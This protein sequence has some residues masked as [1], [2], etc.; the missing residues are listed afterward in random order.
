MTDI[1]R[2]LNKRQDI[3][4]ALLQKRG[5]LGVVEI[6]AEIGQK[7]GETAK[8]TVNRDL[9]GLLRLALIV[10]EGK[11]RAVVYA[12]S[13]R[14]A[15]LR[16]ID[17]EGYFRVEAD[18]RGGRVRF[19]ADIFP[20]LHDP[21]FE[22]E[23]RELYALNEIYRSNIEQL[24]TRAI[25]KEFERLTIELSWKSSQ[26]E[27]NTYNLLETEVLI[28][29]HREAR[30]HKK[31]EAVMI[32]NHKAALDHI[33]EHA[34]RFKTISIRD[35][36]YVHSL[37]TKDLGISPNIRKT[38]VGIVGT[39]YRPL[40]NEFQIR[41]AL[42]RVCD[43]VNDEQDP[44]GKALLISLMIA[45]IQPFEDGN[46]RTS[47]LMANAILLAYDLCPLSYRSVDEVE[48]KKAVILFYERNN[49]TYFKKLFIDQFAFAVKHYF[50][51]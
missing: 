33:R 38:P 20:L 25:A 16:E 7:F 4:I 50:K 6:V 11:G 29:E 24:S 46:K 42:E 5:R 36:E 28:K 21:F 15:L 37:L 39:A 19:N 44:L 23:L 45:Y 2:K 30:G 43:V 22:P 8:V 34:Q 10:R 49:L 27:G 14:Y 3:I 51:A 47:R 40:D 18:K 32:L 35:V 41:E 9:N 13:D 1:A 12:L 31:E 26:I 48:Y 17:V